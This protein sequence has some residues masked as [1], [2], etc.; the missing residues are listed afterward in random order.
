MPERAQC[1]VRPSTLIDT[2]V[3]GYQINPT[4]GQI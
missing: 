1:P 4:F 2:G 3:A